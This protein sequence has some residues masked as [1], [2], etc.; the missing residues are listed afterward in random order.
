[1]NGK[2]K[3][4]YGTV[5]VRSLQWPGSFTF[6]NNEKYT[7]IYVGSGHKYET[8]SFYPLFPPL[9]MSDPLEYGEQPEPTPLFEEPVV[10][11][12]Q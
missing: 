11:E 2:K 6:Y 12:G 1:M 3:V 9:I 8:K 10:E 5:V 4:C 7:S